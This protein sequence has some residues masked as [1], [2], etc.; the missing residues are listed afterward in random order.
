MDPDYFELTIGHA[1]P[2]PEPDHE[3]RALVHHRTFPP[4]HVLS[5]P[6]G[7]NLLP[8]SP[9]RSVTYVSERSIGSGLVFGESWLN[10]LSP[11]SSNNPRWA[12]PPEKDNPCV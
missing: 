10:A 7:Q 12:Q 5:C 3:T 8:M 4:W 11:G 2:V 1:L 6:N 9:E